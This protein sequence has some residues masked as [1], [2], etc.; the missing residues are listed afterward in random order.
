MFR[1]FNVSAANLVLLAAGAR[2]SNLSDTDPETR[3]QC[4][5]CSAA[6][7]PEIPGIPGNPGSHGIPGTMGQKGD[8][9]MNVIY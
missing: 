5:G 9:G 4:C 1:A 6:G 8:R 2:T 3:M 7:I